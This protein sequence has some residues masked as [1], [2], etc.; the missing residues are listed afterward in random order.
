VSFTPSAAVREKVDA[1]IARY[2]DKAAALL[3]VLHAIQAEAGYVP[4]EAEAWVA[5]RL[6][7]LPL[8]VREIVTFYTMFRRA[9]RGRHVLEV[10]RNLSCTLAGSEDILRFIAETLGIGPGETTPDGA[11]SLATVECLGNCDHAPC[12][13]VDGVDH[14]PVTRETVAAILKEL[15][16]HER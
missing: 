1:A 15:Q 4:R 11:I 13:Q 6:G 8:R 7:I 10:C 12:L 2:P 5:E 14:G 3:P 9:P 16:A